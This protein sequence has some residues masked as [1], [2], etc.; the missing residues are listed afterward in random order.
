MIENSEIEEF[1]LK[2]LNEHLPHHNVKDIYH[3]ACLPGGKF[4]RPKLAYSVFNDLNPQEFLNQANKAHSNL[5][6]LAI[7][8]E[9]HHTYTLLHDDLPCMDN[10]RIRR[11]K[12]CTHIQYGE[13]QALL[14]GDGLLNI[15]YSLLSQINHPSALLGIKYFSWSQGPKGLIQGQVLD[16]SQEMTKNFESTMLTHDL[17]T[18][19]LIQSAVMLS[20]LFSHQ[21]RNTSFEKNLWAYSKLLG[22][23]F[24]FLDDLTELCEKNINQHEKDVNP[25][26]LFTEKTA[27]QL[28]HDLKKFEILS[29][30]CQL[31]FTN[32]MVE[33]YY[34]NILNALSGKEEIIK[35]HLKNDCDLN[36]IIFLL[37]SFCQN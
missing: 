20:S 24:Q 13:W 35:S 26:L 27:H 10:D 12:A 1:L 19:R 4:F 18:G 2:L 25:W 23:N 21:K 17:K 31:T 28:A 32:R 3:Y 15:S 34:K 37:K 30:K 33:E 8:L 14:T 6:R 9:L 16:L 36:P 7:A 5:S 29:N 22:R 11:G